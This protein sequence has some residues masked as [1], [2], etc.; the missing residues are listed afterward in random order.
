MKSLAVDCSLYEKKPDSDMTSESGSCVEIEDKVREMK[1]YF[2]K[3]SFFKSSEELQRKKTKAEWLTEGSGGSSSFSFYI[4]NL[5]RV[6]GS[7]CCRKTFLSPIKTTSKSCW[8]LKQLP[9]NGKQTA[10][11]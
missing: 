8:I 4:L 7:L 11:A 2:L 10:L 6:V 5:D 9:V 1:W 3:R